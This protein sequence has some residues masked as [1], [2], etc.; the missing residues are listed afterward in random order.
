LTGNAPAIDVK[1]GRVIQGRIKR[2][3]QQSAFVVDAWQDMKEFTC[4]PIGLRGMC[5][6]SR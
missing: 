3:F 4:I 1:F 2:A 5:R 6:T